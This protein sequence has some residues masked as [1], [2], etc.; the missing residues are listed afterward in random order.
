MFLSLVS[1]W[2]ERQ[3]VE[4]NSFG[5]NFS[6]LFFFLL[7]NSFRAV[8]FLPEQP[9][10]KESNRSVF[11]FF[12]SFLSGSAFPREEK[13]SIPVLQMKARFFTSS[14]VFLVPLIFGSSCQSDWRVK[15]RIQ[16]GSGVNFCRLFQRKASNLVFPLIL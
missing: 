9:M 8:Q 15:G 3:N 6:F 10:M 13:V 12:V 11:Q 16:F 1:L 4:G 5:S 7:R 14:N 2:S